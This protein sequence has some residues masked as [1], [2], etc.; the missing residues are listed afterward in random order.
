M[1]IGKWLRLKGYELKPNQN[2]APPGSSAA[3]KPKPVRER[4]SLSPPPPPPR[5]VHSDL[6]MSSLYTSYAVTFA[7]SV[8]LIGGPPDSTICRQ[9]KRRNIGQQHSR[10]VLLYRIHTGWCWHAAMKHQRL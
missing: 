6:F 3:Y 8:G 2:R 1:P 10:M 5:E 7:A 9:S 4:E